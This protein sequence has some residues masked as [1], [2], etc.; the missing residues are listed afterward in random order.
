MTG[1]EWLTHVAGCCLAVSVA[2]H[3]GLSVGLLAGPQ[4]MVAGSP[5][6]REAKVEAAMP[7][8]I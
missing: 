4:G 6:I 1:L 8:M 3:V 2:S 7:F 5:A